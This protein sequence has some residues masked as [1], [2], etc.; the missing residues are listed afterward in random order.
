MLNPDLPIHGM[1]GLDPVLGPFLATFFRKVLHRVVLGR[2]NDFKKPKICEVNFAP[3]AQILTNPLHFS[4]AESDQIIVFAPA[5][6]AGASY[7]R[8]R[9]SK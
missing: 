5:R 8:T 9:V 2:N 6:S 7:S 3:K 4:I 1:I